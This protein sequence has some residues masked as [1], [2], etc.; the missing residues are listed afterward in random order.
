LILAGLE[1]WVAELQSGASRDEVIRGFL[2]SGEYQRRAVNQM[3]QTFLGRQADPAGL[4]GYAR[5]LADGASLEA[6]AAE[7]L[8]SAE[9]ALAQ[10]A[11]AEYVSGLY[12][13]ILGRTVDSGADAF[14][15]RLDAGESRQD[16]AREILDSG[17][18]SI[19][20]FRKLGEIY[21]ATDLGSSPPA[22]EALDIA[23]F[24]LT[25]SA[26]A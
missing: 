12:R 9:Y 22:D 8:A 18:S 10:P 26:A 2:T 19:R 17:E 11:N 13:D 15:A 23:A 4:E 7:I 20:E 14:V 25:S 1:S 3:Y 16:I 5:A 24:L 6:I 21:F